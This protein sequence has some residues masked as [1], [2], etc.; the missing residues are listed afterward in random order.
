MSSR[1][2][3][4]RAFFAADLIIALG[5]TVTV[6]TLLVVAVSRHNR[7]ADRLAETREAV[8]LAENTMIALQTGQPIP[9]AAQGQKIQVQ[10]LDTPSGVE[11]MA[12]ATVKTVVNGRS[13]TLTGLVRASA[14]STGG[15]SK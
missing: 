12:W 2:G 9:H 4:R 10:K 6:G 5:L 13:A 1:F 3:Q 14:T 7:G 15:A 8:S 11:G